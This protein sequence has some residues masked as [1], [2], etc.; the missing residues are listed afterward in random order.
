MNHTL[1]RRASAEF[2]GTAVLVAAVVGSGIAA[3][4]LSPGDVGL[5]L[6][7]N[8]VATA[9]ALGALIL[10]FGPVSGA[11]FNPVV[12]AVD[13]WLGRRAGTGLTTRDLVGY[14]AA[15][16]AGAAAGA[17][18]ANLMFDLPAV[19]WSQ[20]HRTGGNLWLAEVV[21]TAG[22]I[23][24]IF[25]LARSGRATATPAAVGAYIGAAY[26]FTSS[27]SFAN[28]A[29]TIGRAFTDTF[30]G[31]APTSLPAFVVAQFV[32]GLVAVAALAAWYPQAGNAA[33]VVLVPPLTK[34]TEAR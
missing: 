14:T 6:L 8:S 9:F 22:L 5:Q 16:V 21:A 2:A 11:H 20:T 27:T 26:W 19:A 13:W 3:A 33:D 10:T 30:A 7:E 28:P 24:L 34:E 4:R 1:T 23:V 12:S 31:I 32:G 15:Q 25:A 18:L 17:V 29:V